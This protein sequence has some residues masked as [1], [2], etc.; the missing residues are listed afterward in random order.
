MN[1]LN[2]SLILEFIK[3]V[4]RNFLKMSLNKIENLLEAEKKALNL[5]HVAET[6]GLI[7]A[8]KTEKQL[9][10]EL[11][12]L[13]FEL[14]GIKK[15]WHKRI[16]RSGKNTLHP[17]KE[18]PPDLTIQQDDILFFDFGYNPENK[19]YKFINPKVQIKLQY[20]TFTEVGKEA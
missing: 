4:I 5:F 16:V 2:Y 17:Y 19:K 14:Y 15:F 12:A 8:G 20:T 9:N 7:V 13:A 6:R 3:K 11:F 18:N 10:E 1:A